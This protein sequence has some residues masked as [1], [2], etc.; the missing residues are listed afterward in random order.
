MKKALAFAMAA[1]IFAASLT[2]CTTLKKD[3]DGNIDRGAV[4]NLYLT[5][6]VYSFDPQETIN[7]DSILKVLSMLYEGLTTLDSK[8][9]WQNGVMEDYTVKADDRDGYSIIVDLKETKWSDA[10]PLQATDFVYSWKRL[11][12]PNR[13]GEY[14]ALLYDIKNARAINTCDCSVDNLGVS[15]IDT[16]TLKI[17]FENENVDLDRFF[18]NMASIALVPLK[19]ESIDRYG[20][21]R[22]D[23]S[24]S[25][26]VTNGPFVV[27]KM[28]DGGELRL[29]RSSYY[30]R[31]TEKDA[32]DKYVIPYRLVTS[33]NIDS[34]SDVLDAYNLGNDET[35]K[36]FYIG[37]IPLSERANLEKSA[38]VSDMLMTQTYV[39]NTTN[40]LFEKAEVRRAL[41]MALDREHIAE[42][43]TF[44]DPAVG[45]V[46][47]GAF[48]TSSK[49]S[50]RKNGEDL[51]STGA[52]VDEA[53]SLLSSAGVRSGSFSITI[54]DREE[55]RAVADYVK[56]VW[57]DLGF[58]VTVKT[59]GVKH[60]TKTDSEGTFVYSIDDYQN[61]Y[62]AGEFDVIAV[63]A[64]MG[65]PD[66]FAFLAQFAGDFSGNGI[67]MD[68]GNYEIYGHVSGYS[69]EAY[70]ELI[71]KA[72]AAADADERADALHEAEKLLME[73]MPICP[74]VFMKSAYLSSKI[75]SGFKTDYYG[76]TDFTRVKMKN[77]MKYKTEEVQQ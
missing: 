71:E 22:W 41:S 56:S 5:D 38:E 53:K 45:Y 7:D 32:L 4:I 46:P 19:K 60:E 33:Y 57:E 28:E 11:L 17:T 75:L 14:A 3:A 26:L 47:D 42:L 61:I 64:S 77:Y 62:D 16:Y 68:S 10:R 24:V 55:D 15:A 73:D 43:L 49:N 44:A 63:D 13:R 8:G 25:S 51:I 20:D 76:M 34:L 40:P 70:N 58:K 48:N 39:F 50:F 12:D 66:P 23:K 59:T 30:Y 72:F 74:L 37:T 1:L 31:N 6:E 2:G 27:R 54:R 29:E 52:N 35:G 67:N 18:T 9:K 36:L 21:E 65:S 69:S